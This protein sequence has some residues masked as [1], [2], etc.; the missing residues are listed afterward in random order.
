MSR[1]HVYFSCKW[2]EARLGLR[3]NVVLITLLRLLELLELWY[4]PQLRMSYGHGSQR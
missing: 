1:S 3:V 4:V 2:N